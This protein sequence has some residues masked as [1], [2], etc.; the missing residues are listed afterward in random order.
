VTLSVNGAP[1]RVT[2]NRLSCS[3]AVD[4][5]SLDQGPGGGNARLTLTTRDTCA[6]TVTASES[7]I[8][9]VTPSGTGS[10]TVSVDLEFNSSSVD[11]RGYLT[12]GGLRVDVL[13]RRNDL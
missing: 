4:P 7:W 12:I 11:R 10:G 3:Y 5:A 6:W 2:Q 1:Y 8:K 13:Q 9:V